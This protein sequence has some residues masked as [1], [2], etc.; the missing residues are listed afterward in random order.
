MKVR[1]A[2]T[3]TVDDDYRRAINMFYGRP[4]LAT[5]AEVVEWLRAYGS[6]EDDNLM[7]DLDEAIDAVIEDYGTP[8]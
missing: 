5:R 7:S 8:A 4:G 6:S 1:V 2:Y 3:T